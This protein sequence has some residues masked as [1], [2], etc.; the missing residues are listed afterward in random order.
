VVGSQRSLPDAVQPVARYQRALTHR[1]TSVT[2]RALRPLTWASV[3][4]CHPTRDLFPKGASYSIWRTSQL[5]PESRTRTTAATL[6]PG[7]P[8]GGTLAVPLQ[9]GIAVTRY[10]PGSLGRL[11][12]LNEVSP[13]TPGGRCDSGRGGAAA[14]SGWPTDLPQE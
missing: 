12:G 7:A 5:R 1:R 4:E 8:A 13:R 3:R 6:L 9:P 11:S 10:E 14:S 2:V